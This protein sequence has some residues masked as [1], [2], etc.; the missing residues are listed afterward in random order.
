MYNATTMAEGVRRGSI[1]ERRL[2]FSDS[3]F[4]RRTSNHNLTVDI[5][6]ARRRLEAGDV[7]AN[8]AD[9]CRLCPGHRDCDGPSQEQVIQEGKELFQNFLREEMQSRDLGAHLDLIT[10]VQRYAQFL[11]IFELQ[12]L[13]C[14]HYMQSPA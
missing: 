7:A 2:S 12:M 4:H 14:I 8:P 11:F 1:S 13:L 6:R 5:E 9:T 10:P 3:K